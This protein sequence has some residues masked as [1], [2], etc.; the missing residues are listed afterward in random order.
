VLSALEKELKRVQ[1]PDSM[2][3][4]FLR[5]IGYLK[6]HFATDTNLEGAFQTI[7]ILERLF[8]NEFA[9]FPL[10][11]NTIGTKIQ[12]ASKENRHVRFHSITE[13]IRPY[14]P[15]GY[16]E[17]KIASPYGDCELPSSLICLFSLSTA[18]RFKKSM[19]TFIAQSW[20]FIQLLQQSSKEIE[21]HPLAYD[22]AGI[23]L[24]EHKR[25]IMQG[26]Q[27][28]RQMGL[29]LEKKP[30]FP[31]RHTNPLYNPQKRNYPLFDSPLIVNEASLI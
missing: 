2:P 24:I 7:T 21:V 30:L 15:A 20:P 3:D 1:S 4:S 9:H 18:V 23:Y 10:R 13:C 6:P 27:V 12:D 14:A 17:F 29:H 11:V 5:I 26:Y 25:Y 31:M 19:K 22:P 8:K 16:I 28:L